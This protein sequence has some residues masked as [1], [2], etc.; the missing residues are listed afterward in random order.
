MAEIWCIRSCNKNKHTQ[1]TNYTHTHSYTRVCGL[2]RLSSTPAGSATASGTHRIQPQPTRPA[3]RPTISAEIRFSK[4]AQLEFEA[5]PRALMAQPRVGVSRRR[6]TSPPPKPCARERRKS[7]P[8]CVCLRFCRRRNATSYVCVSVQ[9]GN[10][11]CNREC[12]GVVGLG[13]ACH[14]IT[15][16][17]QSDRHP[18]EH[19]HTRAGRG[20]AYLAIWRSDR[21]R[22]A[23]EP[24]SPACATI[25]GNL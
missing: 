1:N 6:R 16:L 3:E 9:R 5:A 23:A 2:R 24:Q 25:Y 19:A 15:A 20:P 14:A 22:S 7:V 4:V 10:P 8:S 17:C 12:T 18:P 11:Q 21:R 13:S